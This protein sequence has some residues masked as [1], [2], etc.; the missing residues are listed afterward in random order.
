MIGHPEW[1]VTCRFLLGTER[2]RS[3][4]CLMCAASLVGSD[5]PRELLLKFFASDA[6]FDREVEVAGKF[7]A[8]CPGG[9]P[10]KA[11]IAPSIDM[12]NSPCWPN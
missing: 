3:G 11:Q 9:Y 10:P 4:A 2:W 6:D 5:Q 8:H 1:C 12:L 7:Q